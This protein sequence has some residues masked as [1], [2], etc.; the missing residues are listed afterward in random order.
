MDYEDVSLFIGKNVKICTEF[1]DNGGR[2]FY[3]GRIQRINKEDGSFLIL[4]KFEQL[5]LVRLIDVTFVSE[6]K[7]NSNNGGELR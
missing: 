6:V 2:R 7:E 4:D 5:N 3:T 1:D